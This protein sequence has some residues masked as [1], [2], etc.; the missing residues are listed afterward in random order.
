VPT[1]LQRAGFVPGRRC[2]IRRVDPAADRLARQL[3]PAR[4]FCDRPA[5]TTG[6][7]YSEVRS[8]TPAALALSGD[9]PTVAVAA[10][11]TKNGE[12]ATLPLPADL[13][14]FVAGMAP[15]AAVFPLPEKGAA[16]LKVDLDA[17]G[18]A[19]RDAAGLVFD[20]HA[21]GCWCATLAD[22]A[23][24]APWVVQKLMRHRLG[25]LLRAGVGCDDGI[26]VRRQRQGCLPV[27]RGAVPGEVVTGGRREAR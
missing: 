19:Y 21:L 17:A 5:V 23:R 9:M 26:E 16:M 7:R 2:P 22:A 27:A 3:G 11:Y 12:P 4:A 18:I 10:A 6:L 1:T 8:I 20:F 13:A 14:A 15:G 25:D 24:V